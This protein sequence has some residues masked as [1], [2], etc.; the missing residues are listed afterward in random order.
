M[1]YMNRVCVQ[2][3]PVENINPC[4]TSRFIFLKKIYI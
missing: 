1:C 2:T 3:T 4:D